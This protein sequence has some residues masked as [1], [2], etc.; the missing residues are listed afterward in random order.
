MTDLSLPEKDKVP[1]VSVYGKTEGRGDGL[2][3]KDECGC[4]GLWQKCLRFLIMHNCRPPSTDNTAAVVQCEERQGR[5]FF[6]CPNL[7]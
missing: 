5:R 2:K 4:N 1:F 7:N 6:F 3:Q